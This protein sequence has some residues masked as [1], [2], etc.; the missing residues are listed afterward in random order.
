VREFKADAIV[1]ATGGKPVV[2]QIPGLSDF[3]FAEHV[4]ESGEQTGP[5]AVIIGGGMVGCETAVVLAEKGVRVTIVEVL[6][7]VA[8]KVMPMLQRPLLD[9]LRK[10]EVEILTDARIQRVFDHTLF[11]VTEDF[12]V[13]TIEADTI[14]LAAGVVPMSDGLKKLEKLAVE[15]YCAGDCAERRGIREAIAEGNRSARRI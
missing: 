3:L 4:L 2:P 8:G 1:V 9:R 10:K 15:L 11:L 7:K 6:N 5:R 12:G 13:K 14:V